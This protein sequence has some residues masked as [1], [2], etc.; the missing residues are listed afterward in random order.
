MDFGKRAV[1]IT[2]VVKGREGAGGFDELLRRH[3]APL[4]SGT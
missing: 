3:P 4:P 2:I 1:L